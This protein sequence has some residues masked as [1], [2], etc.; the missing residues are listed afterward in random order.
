MRLRALAYKMQS[1]GRWNYPAPKL[2]GH[3]M[4][5]KNV[6]SPTVD[7]LPVSHG[8]GVIPRGVNDLMVGVILAAWVT[9]RWCARIPR[10]FEEQRERMNG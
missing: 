4:T 3:T 2:K 6:V 8:V 5:L 7:P 10:N 1:S 9:A